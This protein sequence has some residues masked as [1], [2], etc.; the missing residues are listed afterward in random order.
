MLRRLAARRAGDG[1]NSRAGNEQHTT[2]EA[3]QEEE[4]EE[5]ESS[6]QSCRGGRRVLHADAA[7]RRRCTVQM[8]YSLSRDIRA[9]EVGPVGFE[10][11]SRLNNSN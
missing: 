7:E 3:I 9:R 4:N 10:G 8:R 11:L 6:V 5:A 1:K 2:T